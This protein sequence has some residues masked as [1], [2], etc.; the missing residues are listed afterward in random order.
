[1]ADK[2]IDMLFVGTVTRDLLENCP[3][4][5]YR[6]GGT[7]S[8]GAATAMR[9]GWQ[10]TIVT[11]AAT[12]MNFT[13]L[14]ELVGL[15]ILPSEV[16]TTFANVYTSTGRIQYCYTPTEAITAADIPL[17]LRHPQ[18]VLLA[19]LVD[20]V[21]ADVA[22]VFGKETLIAATPQGWMRCWGENGRVYSKPWTEVI[23][24][25]RQLDVLVL[26]EE[27]IDCDLSRLNPFIAQV[28]LVVL[29]EGREGCT[30]YRRDLNGDVST[31]KIPPRPTTEVDPT[32]A[33][34]IFATAF[35]L[36]LHKTGEP[37]HAARYA[38]ITASFAVEAPGVL[39]IP[40]HEQV[41]AYLQSTNESF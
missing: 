17:A 37:L 12:D 14:P 40:S 1:M 21:A 16:T 34:D 24:V 27:D 31:T 32:G 38:N 18:V 11:R 23:A 28:P 7:V 13:E 8:F 3:D 22:Q 41:M 2:K 39:D 6:L 15:H 5:S 10:P 33:G 29:T 35:L 4:S 20:D 19:P 25:L 9:L 30:V 36:R 26:S